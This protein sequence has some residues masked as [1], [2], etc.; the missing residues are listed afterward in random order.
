MKL[1]CA[2]AVRAQSAFQA[3]AV[4]LQPLGISAAT[5]AS[6]ISILPS[7]SCELVGLSVDTPVLALEEALAADGLVGYRKLERKAVVKFTRHM[8]VLP[9][10]AAL[11]KLALD[12]CALRP[13]RYQ[14]LVGE[15][16]GEYDAEGDA[17]DFDR[18][19]LRAV[20]KDYLHADPA[21]RF[22]I[23]K[24]RFERALHDAKVRPTSPGRRCCADRD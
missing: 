6:R 24:N 1:T 20:L 19:S 17:E 22:L 8:H 21:T 11:G 18:F 4:S 16:P 9:G 7:F 5:T 14:P 13:E 23:A 12:G 3:G 10:M 2:Q 15:G